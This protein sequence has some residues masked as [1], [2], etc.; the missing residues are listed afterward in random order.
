MVYRRDGVRK[1]LA[2]E[3]PVLTWRE[4]VGRFFGSLEPA[5]TTVRTLVI[6]V[7]FLLAILAVMP[8]LI[9]QMFR[10]EVVIEP[11]AVPEPMAQVGYTSEVIA[12]RLWDGIQEVQN[13]T[14]TS[15]E[16]REV[17]PKSRRVQFEFP[18]S[19]L[20]F[21]SLIHHIRRFFSA[22]DTS[23]GGEIVCAGECR[24]ETMQLRI[25]VSGKESD[26]IVLPPVGDSTDD[27]YFRQAGAEILRYLD[28][29]VAASYLAD[30]NPERGITAL[31]RLVRSHHRDAKWAHNMIGLLLQ[32]RGETDAAIEQFNAAL[33][34]DPE[35]KVAMTNLAGALN[36]KGARDRAQAMFKRVLELDPQF[37]LAFEG[38]ARVATS[39]NDVPGAITNYRKASECDPD[40]P[41]PVWQIGMIHLRKGDLDKAIATFRESLEIDPSY[42][43]SHA[44]LAFAFMQKSDYPAV[45]RLYR[46]I[47]ELKPNDASA[48]ADLASMLAIRKDFKGAAESYRR[49]AELAP[50]DARWQAKLGDILRSDGRHEEAIV[51]LRQA[52]A[53]DPKFPD[54]HFNLGLSLMQT[55]KNEEARSA[56]REFITREPESLY[57]PLAKR[58]LELLGG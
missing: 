21:E 40:A 38:L 24:R 52:I 6:N 44:G 13:Q 3:E 26:V 56:F 58:Y 48:H 49:A 18:D 41:R 16:L 7:A 20:S 43:P 27:A 29:F 14:Q 15:K 47:V 32:K 12:N 34:I 10:D 55:A 36:D 51:A 35:F 37:C 25:R 54:A 4:R 19:G 30:T 42:V 8:V 28:P 53:L 46:D 39:A 22:Y 5:T 23:V 57:L 17:T 45:E 33:A 2:G 31:K 11:V 50:T 1:R 9:A